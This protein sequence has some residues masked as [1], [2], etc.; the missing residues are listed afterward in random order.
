MP[1]DYKPHVAHISYHVLARRAVL[2]CTYLFSVL[3]Y[4]R[5]ISRLLIAF[6]LVSQDFIAIFILARNQCS[7]FSVA[8]ALL[9]GEDAFDTG[10]VACVLFQILMAFAPA[11]WDVWGDYNT[12]RKSILTLFLIICHF[13]VLTILIT[14][15]ANT[16]M[17]IVKVSLYIYLRLE[18]NGKVY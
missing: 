14:G 1:D 4:Y 16:F 2:L 6:R 15:L 17:A 18:V 9:F 5:Y 8:F 11:A 12:L 10:N 13:L 7:G 3:D